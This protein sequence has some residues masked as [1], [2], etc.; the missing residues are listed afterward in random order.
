MTMLPKYITAEAVKKVLKMSD[1]IP[2]IERGMG[3]F[4]KHEAGGVIQPV[5]AVIPVK[6]ADGFIGSM[7]AY[8]GSDGALGCKLVSF[9]HENAHRYKDISTHMA[10]ILLYNHMTGVLKAIMDGEVIT[11][12]RT[13]AA[14]AVAT[15]YLAPKDSKILCILGA[16]TQARSHYQALHLV[17]NFQQTKIWNHRRVRAETFADEYSATVCDTAEEAAKDA[18]VIVVATSSK[19]P[20]LQ[21]QWV[22]PGAHINGI[23]ACTHDWQEMSSELMQN[24]VVYADS[25]DAAMVEAGDVILSKAEVYGEIGDLVNG[26]KEAFTGKT[27][28]FKSLGMAIE[29]I[30]AAKLVYE[31]CEN[32]PE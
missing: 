16:G 8:D 3:E 20:V 19:T 13:A 29:D 32:D 7:P 4:S 14:S 10:T 23:G 15:K 28:V 25:K 17:C 9:Y 2:V 5:R 6:E 1:L 12:M 24:A 21:Y 30:V 26:T 18:D 22:K 27:T 31:K 11:T